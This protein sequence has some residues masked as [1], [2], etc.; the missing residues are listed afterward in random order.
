MLYTRYTTHKGFVGLS[1]KLACSVRCHPVRAGL[2]PALSDAS[3]SPCCAP[4][5]PPSVSY[6]LPVSRAISAGWSP[7]AMR[8]S[9]RIRSPNTFFRNEPTRYNDD[10]LHRVL[11]VRIIE[12]PRRTEAT[13]KPISV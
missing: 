8:R 9:I 3:S 11:D 7:I 4:G 5:A 6:S 1:Q 12:L 10:V 13:A 2:N